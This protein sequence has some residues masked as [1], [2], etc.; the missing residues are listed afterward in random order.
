MKSSS[1]FE[2]H[3]LLERQNI[4]KAEEIKLRAFEEMGIKVV[5]AEQATQLGM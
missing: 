4:R 1:S 2:E 3:L 5:T